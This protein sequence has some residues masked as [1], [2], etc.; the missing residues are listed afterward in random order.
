MIP[1][2]VEFKNLAITVKIADWVVNDV[3]P[4]FGND[5]GNEPDDE[6]NI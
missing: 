3:T 5:N 2:V 4:G 1:I 6:N